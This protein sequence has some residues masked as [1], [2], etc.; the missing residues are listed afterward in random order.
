VGERGESRISKKRG[1]GE[2]LGLFGP[3]VTKGIGDNALGMKGIASDS[4]ACKKA[5]LGG[6]ER[7]VW[8]APGEGNGVVWRRK[9]VKWCGRDSQRVH[10]V[11]ASIAV[12][13]RSCLFGRIIHDSGRFVKKRVEPQRPQRT[14]R[15]EGGSRLGDCGFA[16]A[17][18]LLTAVYHELC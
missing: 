13:W 17:L 1:G 3:F 4:R 2:K 16:I 10:L 7:R 11:R 9:G 5:Q 6:A 15:T 8:E 18:R 14:W 12:D